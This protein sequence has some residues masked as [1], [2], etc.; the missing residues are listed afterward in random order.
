MADL[1]ALTL[2]LPWVPTMLRYWLRYVLKV[3]YLHTS[4][5]PTPSTHHVHPMR[6]PLGTA[7]VVGRQAA[8]T[9]PRYT[10]VTHASAY[11]VK[12]QRTIPPVPPLGWQKGAMSHTARA[13]VSHT[14][15][16]PHAKALCS[17]S[18]G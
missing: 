9:P 10:G 16:S 3:T 7:T 6:P 13:I 15:L 11:H 14:A 5:M 2:A 1:M 18:Y 17:G 8:S 12:A 4:P